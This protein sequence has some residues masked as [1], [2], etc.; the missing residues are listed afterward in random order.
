MTQKEM[1]AKMEEMMKLVAG[2]TAENQALKTKAPEVKQYQAGMVLEGETITVP[3]GHVA[4]VVPMDKSGKTTKKGKEYVCETRGTAL[5]KASG[6]GFT[7]GLWAT[8]AE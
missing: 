1:L 5:H 4:L 2:L 6:A 7:F 3:T 8:K